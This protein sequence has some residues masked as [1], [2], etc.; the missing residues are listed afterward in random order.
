M[1]YFLRS[2]YRGIKGIKMSII[3]TQKKII[4]VTSGTGIPLKEMF[5]DP[6]FSQ[7]FSGVG[8]IVSERGYKLLLEQNKNILTPDISLE[9]LH[10]DMVEGI[11]FILLSEYLDDFYA[12]QQPLLDE[13]GLPYSV[14][15]GLRRPFQS[16][17]A[18]VD[19]QHGA[20]MATQHL[21]EHGYRDVGYVGFLNGNPYDAELMAGYRRVLQL[22]Q[23]TSHEEM[24]IHAK[25]IM[26]EDGYRLAGEMVQR[27]KIPRALFVG[28]TELARGMYARFMEEGVSVPGDCAIIAYG[29]MNQDDYI[30]SPITT[31]RQPA[32]EVGCA[33]TE[34]LFESIAGNKPG[35]K[36]LTGALIIRK[37][38]GC[39]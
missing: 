5:A 22:E 34:I 38:C 19:T 36:I 18:G 37:S 3:T 4:G 33:A 12:K 2:F 26:V 28:R 10:A 13:I 7:L 39:V 14:I 6:Y 9:K 11:V 15:V 8:D 16:P 31:V 17:T 32:F 1:R 35:S 25:G 21:L 29:V 23:I 20:Y 30:L 27:G 24:F